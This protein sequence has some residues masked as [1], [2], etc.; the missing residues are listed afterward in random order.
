MQWLPICFNWIESVFLDPMIARLKL[1]EEDWEIDLAKPLDISLEMAANKS[2]ARAWYVD[3]VKITPVRMGDWVGEVASG[4]S[5]NFR[6]ID[7]NPH[8]N[9]TH[10][11]CLG[12]IT[13]EVFSVNDALSRYFFSAVLVSIRP[14]ERNGDYIITEAQLESAIDGRKPEAVIIRTLPNPDT[15]KKTNYS[16]T[17]PTY[18]EQHAATYLRVLGVNHLLIDTPSVDREEDGGELLSHHA[19]WNVPD[20][21]RYRAT[22]TEL[23]Y[24]P[25][26]IP[27]GTYVLNIQ[28]APFVN[29]ASPSRPVLY[30]NRLAN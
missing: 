23:I 29:D 8:G 3:P 10:T 24:V 4:G 16:N 20:N 14:E 27:D 13:E 30:R 18:M 17:N 6:D 2:S 9:G 26:E 7:F 11:E 22:I 12:H 21:P 19:F 28:M 25:D 15:K 5:V 1:G